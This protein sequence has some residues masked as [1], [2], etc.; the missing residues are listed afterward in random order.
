MLPPPTGG[1]IVTK[2]MTIE[3]AERI[4]TERRKRSF[5]IPGEIPGTLGSK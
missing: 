4:I 2:G 5:L 1:R 3:E